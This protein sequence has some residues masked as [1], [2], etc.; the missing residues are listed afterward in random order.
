MSMVASFKEGELIEGLISAL[1]MLSDTA[2]THFAESG[3]H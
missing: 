3:R 2:G 1:R